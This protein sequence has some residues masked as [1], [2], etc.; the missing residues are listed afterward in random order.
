M[1]VTGVGCDELSWIHLAYDRVQLWAFFGGE[2]PRSRGYGRTVTLR[3]IVQPCDEG[4]EEDD[5]F[6][7]FSV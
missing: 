2:G 3:L 7:R 5:K 4:E 1:A 6:F